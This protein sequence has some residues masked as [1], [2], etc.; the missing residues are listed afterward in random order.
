MNCPRSVR[1]AWAFEIFGKLTDTIESIFTG[2]CV[3]EILTF[4]TANI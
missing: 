1:A 3:R 4:V 2:F